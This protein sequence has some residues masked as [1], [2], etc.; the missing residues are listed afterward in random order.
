M[1]KWI[2]LLLLVGCLFNCRGEEPA[3]KTVPDMG[4]EADTVAKEVIKYFPRVFSGIF[5]MHAVKEESIDSF[6]SFACGKYGSEEKAKEVFNKF[7]LGEQFM[8]LC[9]WKKSGA[10]KK[11]FDKYVKWLKSDECR[12]QLKAC[13]FE[14]EL[15]EADVE[16]GIAN[17]ISTY[18]QFVNALTE[19]Q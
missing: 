8:L 10:Y 14:L 3:E 7:S 6:V 1:K 5:I 15:T 11:I 18:R 16:F 19:K 4:L 13:D 2:V 12:E 17:S 9:E